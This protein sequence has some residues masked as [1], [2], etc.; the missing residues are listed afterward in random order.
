MEGS[1]EYSGGG[2]GIECVRA[3]CMKL[4]T[5]QCPICSYICIHIYIYIFTSL[6]IHIYLCTSMHMYICIHI[7]VYMYIFDNTRASAPARQCRR[8]GRQQAI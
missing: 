7:H 6:Y 5:I 2:V 4:A 8:G 3:R 1:N